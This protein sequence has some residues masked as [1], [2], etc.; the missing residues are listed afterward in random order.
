LNIAPQ[1]SPVVDRRYR[2]ITIVI[3]MMGLMMSAIDVTAVVLAIPNMMND[4]SSNLV[5]MVWVMMGYLL[6]LTILGTQVGRIGDMFGRIRVY[7]LGFGLFTL[8]SLLCGF[9]P[10]GSSLI[11]F[12]VVQAIGGAFIASNAGA[13]IADTFPPSERGKAYGMFGIGAGLGQILGILVGGAL[14]TFLSW[15]YIF[16]INVPIGVPATIAGYFLLKERSPR[17]KET[18]DIA[19]MLLLGAAL[20]LV[21]YAINSTTGSGWSPISG[22]ELAS[23]LVLFGAFV[24]QERRIASPL[25][26]LSL[27][28]QRVLTASI[29]ASLVQ[30]LSSFAVLFLLMMYLQGPR[31]LSPWNASLLL[32]PGYVLSAISISFAGG[33]SDRLGARVVASIGLVLQGLGVVIYST[34]TLDSSLFLVTIGAT[35]T[36]LGNAFFFPANTSAIMASA[37]PRAY[38]VTA[39]LQ[40]TFA[41]MG[42]VGSF[43]LAL[44]IASLSVPRQVAVGIFLGIGGIQGGLSADFISGM[45]S[46][47]LASISLLLVAL[48]L[49]ILRGKEART[50]RASASK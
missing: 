44:L 34:F 40:R 20:F 48:T 38:G 43:A 17:L 8:G 21:L 29:L 4:L 25:L 11:A 13:I 32:V 30:A 22:L 41:N 23:A 31:G 7:N 46:A 33:L 28:R 27:L 3:T 36:G 10:S 1:A 14:V 24:L 50:I 2:T 47:L 9:S 5:T 15:R 12:R 18:L 16:F 45:H 35:V 37:P 19:G 49:S 42:M 6:V 39:G 26:D